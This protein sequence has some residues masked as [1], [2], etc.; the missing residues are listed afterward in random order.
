VNGFA[1]RVGQLLAVGEGSGETARAIVAAVA[2]E[3]GDGDA[4]A[5]RTPDIGAPDGAALAVGGLTA[6]GAALVVRGPATGEVD[7]VRVDGPGVHRVTGPVRTIRLELPPAGLSVSLAVAPTTAVAPLG[8]D[9]GD[10]GSRPRQPD[11]SAPF[12]SVLLVPGYAPAPTPEPIDA[13]AVTQPLVEG[14]S[15]KYGHFNDP[16]LRYCQRCGISMAQLTEVSRLGPRPPLGVLLLDDGTTLRLDTDYVVGQEPETDPDVVTGRARPVRMVGSRGV[17]R[18]HIRVSL[19]GW[20]VRI[21]DLHSAN[22]TYVQ[23]PDA[24]EAERLAPGVPVVVRP[25]TRVELGRRWLRYESH[26]NP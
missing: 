15:C 13:Y 1:V 18:R 17:S 22:G 16:A 19:S 9:A 20:S 11:R 5:R 25:G 23:Q 26:R 24:P 6:T 12:Q 2:A 14:V 3:G 10:V 21:L 8:A 4:L 7:G